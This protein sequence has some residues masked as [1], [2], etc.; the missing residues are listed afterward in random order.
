MP[1]QSLVQQTILN[2]QYSIAT[3]INNNLNLTNKGN[4]PVKVYFIRWFSLNLRGLIYQDSISDYT[5]SVTT[6]IYDRIN[7]FVGIPYGAQLDPNFQGDSGGT[8]P[9][10]VLLAGY[11]SNKIEFTT[12]DGSPQFILSDYANSYYPL[13]GNN[14]EIQVYLD[15]SA[16]DGDYQTAPQITYSTPGDPTTNITQILWDYPVGV[17]G[18]LQISGIAPG[19][20]QSGGGSGSGAQTLQFNEGNLLDA[21]GGNWYLPLSV[22]P[23]L[24]FAVL[25]NGV[26]ISTTYDDTTSPARLYGFANDDSPQIIKVRVI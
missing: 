5:S 18:Y 3:L 17:S 1:N 15:Q 12:T 23:R 16:F 9:T 22:E 4:V 8:P 13:Y 7:G 24:P 14:P 6:T 10:I 2:G 25:S 19:S 20:Q 26:A 21:G 11:N